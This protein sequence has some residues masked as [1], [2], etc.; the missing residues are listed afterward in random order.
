[1]AIFMKNKLV[2]RGNVTDNGYFDIDRKDLFGGNERE[3]GVAGRVHVLTG[4]SD[5]VVPETFAQR[6][7]RTAATM[8]GFRGIFSLLLLGGPTSGRKGFL[9]SSNYPSVSNVDVRIRR[10]SRTLSSPYAVIR[11]EPAR[12][13]GES[14]GDYDFRCRNDTNPAHLIHECLVNEDWGMGGSPNLINASSFVA[15]AE[16]LYNEKFGLSMLWMRQ[17]TIK[18]FIQE[19][20]DHIQAL[21]YFNPKSGLLEIK[22]LRDDYEK[23][24]LDEI[25]PD[26]A[27]LENF[28]RQLW[29]ETVNEIVVSW[30]N[31]AT[32]ESETVTYQDLANIAMQGEV[33]SES[34][35]YYG[36]RNASL[37]AFVAARDIRSSA[38]PLASAVV[39]LNRQF[40]DILPGE[41]YFFTW[42]EHGIEKVIMRVMDVDYGKPDSAEMKVT[43]LEDVFGI[44]VAEFVPPEEPPITEWEDP[45]HDP[46]GSDPDYTDLDA[47]F[48]S[49][50][51]TVIQ[52]ITGADQVSDD[53]Y[54]TI[55]PLSIVSRKTAQTDLQSYVKHRRMTIQTGAQEF[56]SVGEK[57]LVASTVLEAPLPREVTSD[58]LAG[59]IFEFG[60]GPEVGGLGVIGGGVEYDHEI[61][62]VLEDLGNGLFRCARG[63]YDT[64]PRAWSVGQRIHWMGVGYN[65]YDTSGAIAD[66]ILQYKLQARTSVGL[67]DLDLV[68][69]KTT[70]HPPRPYMPYRPA[71]V[72]MDGVLFADRDQTE[73][74]EPRVW[75]IEYTWSHRNRL[76]EDSV[77]RAWNEASVPMETGQ[78]VNAYVTLAP[79]DL[80]PN[81]GEDKYPLNPAFGDNVLA[82]KLSSSDVSFTLDLFQTR[83]YL[84]LYFN[85]ISERDGFISLQADQLTEKMYP[86]GF[87]S[88]FGYFWG[89]WPSE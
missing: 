48:S 58:I 50:P 31:P 26:N 40:W 8:P 43:L 21:L 83:R 75:T 13:A 69:Q 62:M 41:V 12:K 33:V 51:P 59:E 86:K 36:I 89:G 65:G 17:E 15:A 39:Y 76:T 14:D 81:E 66:T 49:A 25:G 88:D 54:P 84:D 18:A 53:Q 23:D 74:Y 87:G 56:L 71:N 7:G 10:G 35:D 60:D 80:N 19:I 78:A 22:L 44:S 42:P 47:I 52:Q 55:V 30:T 45:E 64:V 38:I 79:V 73:N 11:Y 46:N 61:I 70:Q 57:V 3:G 5:Q 16:T 68:P 72:Q 4:K 1:M 85:A 37:A 67:T 27:R 82:S 32:E 34:R 20:L 29:G 63:V 9:V 77:Y 2:W 6:L 24:N 28:R